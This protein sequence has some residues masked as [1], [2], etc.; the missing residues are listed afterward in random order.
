MS[1]VVFPTPMAYGHG[2][3]RVVSI[4]A[5]GLLARGHDLVMF[6]KAGSQFSG[7]AVL[8]NADGYE[9]EKILAREVMKLNSDFSF[10]CFIDN[11]HVHYLSHMLPEYP[12]VNIY[13]DAY[14]NYAP[15]PVMLSEGQRA[16]MP[17]VFENARIIHNAL[18]PQDYQPNFGH[19]DSPYVLLVGMSEIKQ[20]ILA[21]EACARLGLKLIIAGQ[22]MTGKFPITQYSNVEYV[23]P[24]SGQYKVDLFRNARVFLTL[25]I[26]SFGLTTL[27]AGLY[28]TPVCGWPSGGTLDLIE[29]G[30]NGA[31]V[32]TAGQDK[33]QNV[34]DAIERCWF[35]SRETC[36]DYTERLCKPEAQIDA[37]EQCC[38]D[39]TRGVRW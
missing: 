24:V 19:T 30:V 4:V 10:D 20:P 12:V 18:N 8:V 27:E 37:Y 22:S 28:G 29:Y 3:G 1:D 13:H 32:T 7:A 14:Q 38:A 26:E 21:I 31:F 17:P 23:G 35:I 34:A 9:G 5:E 16:L 39:V 2:L 6:A 15:C 25:G 11:G 36:R 33:V